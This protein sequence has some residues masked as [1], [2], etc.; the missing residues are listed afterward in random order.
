[1]L[2]EEQEKE[3]GLRHSHADQL[4]MGLRTDWRT[5]G[6]QN[7]SARVEKHRL[8]DWQTVDYSVRGKRAAHGHHFRRPTATFVEDGLLVGLQPCRARCALYPCPK[9]HRHSPTNTG[10]I[11]DSRVNGPCPRPVNTGVVL[12]ARVHGPCMDTARE[13]DPWIWDWVGLSTN[14]NRV[15][16][17]CWSVINTGEHGCHFLTPVS[18]GRG[19]HG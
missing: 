4:H 6:W 12:N 5:D 1:L 17:P 8:F 13:H 7:G 11:F 16:G 14:D 19:W 2:T 15:H 10:V 9:W 18:T 3:T